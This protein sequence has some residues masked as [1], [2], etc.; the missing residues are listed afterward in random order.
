MALRVEDLQSERDHLYVLLE[1]CD[2]QPTKAIE[3]VVGCS[4]YMQ[5]IPTLT[6]L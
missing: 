3:K 4:F 6:V 1:Q 2:P 5:L